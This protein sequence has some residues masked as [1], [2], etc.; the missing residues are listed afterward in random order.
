MG[1]EVTL[2]FCFFISRAG[3]LPGCLSDLEPPACLRAS[4][5]LNLSMDTDASQC[6]N[7]GL[8]QLR[9]IVARMMEGKVGMREKMWHTMVKGEAS[10]ASC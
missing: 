2:A 5:F 1:G 8:E 7:G 9:Q 10:G 3:V 4:R 6:Q